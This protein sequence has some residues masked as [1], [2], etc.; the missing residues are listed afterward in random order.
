[1]GQ[2]YDIGYGVTV[3]D[4]VEVAEHVRQ[5]IAAGRLT[6]AASRRIFTPR[7]EQPEVCVYETPDQVMEATLTE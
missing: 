6:W 4:V 7:A 5:L 2:N 1:V 3:H